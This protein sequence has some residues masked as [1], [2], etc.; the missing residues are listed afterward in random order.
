MDLRGKIGQRLVFGF[1][2]LTVPE[3]FAALVREYKI[4]NII[5]FRY[6]VESLPQLT[7][8]CAELQALVREATGHA[9]FITI[10]QEGGM[11]TRLPWDA[12]NV[13]GCMALAA[14]GDAE[15]ARLAAEITA[16]Q[17]RGCGVNFNLAP[18][19]D[20]NSNP[21]NPVI[22]V[23]SFGDTPTRAAALGAAAVR[24]YL[25][26]G[27]LCCGKHFPGHGDTA[28][29]S[30]LGLPCI[31]KSLAELEECE[32]VP[33]RAAVAE[34]IPA[35]M[36]SHILFPKIEPDGVPATMSRR[37]MH[38][39]LRGQLGFSGLVLSDCMVMDAI[40]QHYGTARGVVAAMRAGVDMVFV[41]SSAQLQRES[42]AAALAA[43]ERGEIDA[44]ELD[45]SVGRILAARSRWAFESAE[46]SLAGREED[47][48]AAARMARQAI[49]AVRGSAAPVS[50]ATFFCGCADYRM[51]LVANADPDAVP[52][53]EYMGRQFGANY[54]VCSKDPDAA[55]I[56]KIA[57]LASGA[58]NIVFSSCN[59]HLFRGQIALA[60]A[61]S[62]L[63]VPLTVAALRN[64]Y[65]LPLMPENAALLAAFDYTR[66]SLAALADVL[67]GGKCTGSMPVTL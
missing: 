53:P 54:A 1:R 15:N 57:A 51:A 11:V 19:L 6:N 12:V 43:A 13:S 49:A 38:D 4:A 14:T 18:D 28:V 2:G 10:D 64:P 60:E 42:A 8:L 34:G 63:G 45:E 9:A 31:D 32:L 7:R 37:I 39:L 58:D 59:A 22:G 66:D 23:R 5:L 56:K 3:D 46:P 52:F 30:H 50:G 17:L 29:D 55:E 62:H 40:R 24:G 44:A 16:R 36:S 47:F 33:F 21:M 48:A 41:S 20:V 65:D 27:M 61:L 26:G 25:S 67:S 35:I